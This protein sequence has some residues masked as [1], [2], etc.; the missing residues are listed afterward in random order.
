M[1]LSSDPFAVERQR[2]T[3]VGEIVKLMPDVVITDDILQHAVQRLA[4]GERIGECLVRMGV[5][6][7]AQRDEALALQRRLRG[8]KSIDDV[9]DIL[10]DLRQHCRD[11]CTAAIA[12][13]EA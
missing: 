11:T 6:T 13:L 3:S 9:A 8:A 12:A 2:R 5:L 1:R 4:P 7:S 10:D